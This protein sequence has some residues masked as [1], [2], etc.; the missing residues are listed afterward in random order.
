MQVVYLYYM[1]TCMDDFYLDQPEP[2]RSCLLTLRNVILDMDTEVAGTVKYGMPCFTYRGKAFCY[3][4]K[5]KKTNQPYILMVEGKNLD[6][7]MLELGDRARMKILRV[8]PTQDIPIDAIKQVLDM[9]L[10]LYKN[11]VVKVK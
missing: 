4:W 11:G 5:D 9:A 10:E 8:D 6:H 7:P 2:N 3:L 1:N